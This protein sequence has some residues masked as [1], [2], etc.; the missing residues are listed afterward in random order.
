MDIAGQIAIKKRSASETAAYFEG[1]LNG[2]QAAK[3]G[4]ESSIQNYEATLRLFSNE[5]KS[6]A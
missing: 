6:D 1:F 3:S 5:Q 2:L 4:I